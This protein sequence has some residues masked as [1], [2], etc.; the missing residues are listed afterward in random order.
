MVTEIIDLVNQIQKKTD[1][2]MLVTLIAD[3]VSD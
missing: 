2:R 3:F 1:K